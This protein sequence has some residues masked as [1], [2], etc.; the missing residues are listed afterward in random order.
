MFGDRLDTDILFGI[1]AG[2]TTVLTLTGITSRTEAQN[3]PLKPDHVIENFTEL[4]KSK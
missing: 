4:I 3:S 2:L 1:Q